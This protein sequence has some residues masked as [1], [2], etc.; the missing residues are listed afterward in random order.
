LVALMGTFLALEMTQHAGQHLAEQAV[1][2][3]VQAPEPGL[4]PLLQ[5]GNAEAPLQLVLACAPA[6]VQ[7]IDT[8]RTWVAMQKALPETIRLVWLP[9]A[10]TDEERPLV[11]VLL[12]ARRQVKLWPLL[13]NLDSTA[14]WTAP[15]VQEAVLAS[16]GE[17]ER[18]DKD[19]ADPELHMQARSYQTMALGLLIGQGGA[20]VAG[21]AVTLAEAAAAAESALADTQSRMQEGQKTQDLLERVDLP[22]PN[23]AER[24]QHWILHGARMPAV[25]PSDQP[26]VPAGTEIEIPAG[27]EPELEP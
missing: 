18:L 19:L 16:G 6:T 15:L 10:A 20:L 4:Q 23:A 17:R 9:L 26:L 11:D 2:R 5:L 24:Y 8:A 21:K 7:C 12:A 27:T 3:G 13:E 14:P 25:A 22:D 1:E